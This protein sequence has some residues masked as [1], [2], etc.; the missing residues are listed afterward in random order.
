MDCFDSCV[1]CLVLFL[2]LTN[3]ESSLSQNCQSK[4]TCG[5]C[6]Q[7]LGCFWCGQPVNGS[8]CLST[9]QDSLCRSREKE[10]PRSSFQILKNGELSESQQIRPQRARLSLRKNEKYEIKLQYQ[11]SVNYP[12]DLYYVMDLSFSML[13]SKERVGT[14]GQTIANE[15]RK[16]S[17]NFKIGFG[18]FVDKLSLPYVNTNPSA[19]KNPC[20]N[21]YQCESPYSFKNHL[22]MTDDPRQFSDVVTKT[23]ISGNMDTPESGFDALMQAMVCDN[24]G[25]RLE[26]RHLL[27]MST[28]A[29]SHI[30]GDG[31]L[32]GIIEPN[33]AQCHLERDAK[34][35]TDTYTKDLVYDYPSVSHINYI[36]RKNNINIIFAIITKNATILEN[37]YRGI[38]AA[39][40][41]SKLAIL[42]ENSNNIVNMVSRIYDEIQSAVKITS[43]ANKDVSVRFS[44]SCPGFI[45]GSESGYCN[46]TLGHTIDF[47]VTIEP[48]ECNPYDNNKRII[49]I[50]PEG[51]K[52][53]LTIELEVLCDCDCAKSKE[54]SAT[55]CSSQGDFECG[56]CICHDGWFGENCKCG[57]MA[58]G[59][60]DVASCIKPD[61][62]NKI[63]SGQGKCIC[64]NC[65]CKSRQNEN[66]HIY[67]KYCDCDDFSCPLKCSGKGKC[68]CGKC[69]CEK[70]WTGLG[71]DCST[72][73]S[74]CI[75][76]GTKEI[77]SGHGDCVCGQCQCR[78]GTER[79]SG[80]FCEDCTSCSAQRCDEFRPCIEHLILD[81]KNNTFNNNFNI[82]EKCG[83]LD[84]QLVDALEETLPEGAKRCRNLVDGDCTINFMYSYD[85][86]TIM[87]TAEKKKSCPE[88]PNILGLII[89]IVGSIILAGIV[90][91]II[92]KLVTTIHDKNEYAKFEKERENMKWS[93]HENP[94]YKPGTSTFTNPQYGRNSQRQSVKYTK[95]GDQLKMDKE[96]KETET[97]DH[98]DSK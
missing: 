64:G 91:L 58:D 92:W 67:G 94:L 81:E 28:D 61:G 2:V 49:E 88:P 13:S 20:S 27:I 26:A 98:M 90:S 23:R 1:K 79:R 75:E 69:I 30:A 37:H 38:S 18:S 80:A 71:C 83:N 74:Q 45:N 78:E 21:N 57:R 41:G 36:A 63:C 42:T 8:Y 60:E 56:I 16:K 85:D 46:V 7:E 73:T 62:T 87:L 50:K 76:P 22:P 53:S 10:N 89:G 72:E 52:D 97:D 15:M 4:Q 70:G 11:Q 59:S 34:D 12:I 3:I 32:G 77:C 65:K 68:D 25:W 9:V 31:K 82:S 35:N 95:E 17:N 44:S 40:D 84:I 24:I 6:I 33:D 48:L 19:L 39:I 96:P 29:V 43:N 93:R 47:T 14:L 66:E 86:Q 54:L 5:Q 55:T 51:L